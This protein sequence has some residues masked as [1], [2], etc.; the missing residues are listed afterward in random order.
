M[1][2]FCV[3]AARRMDGL[4]H[5]LL[6]YMRATSADETIEPVPVDSAIASALLNLQTA[7]DESS[8]KITCDAMPVVRMARVH[9]HQIFQNL[10]GN[11][12][13]YR[14]SAP[15]T[16]HVG[17]RRDGADWIFSV[18][19]NGI[20]IEPR[21]QSQVFGLFKRLDADARQSGSGIGLALCKK[22]VERYGGRI[23]VESEPGKGSVFSFTLPVTKVQE[24][25]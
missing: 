13:K 18:R 10:I 9:V 2:Q 14:G 12:L 19:D 23:W 7:I 5:D 6:V 17:A 22:L 20:G 8:A 21:Y 1:I 11:A 16:I 25:L 3:D 24:S 4:I 15:P